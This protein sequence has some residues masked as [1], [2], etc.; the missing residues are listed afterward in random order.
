MQIF[1]CILSCFNILSTILLAS[2]CIRKLT[3]PMILSEYSLCPNSTSSTSTKSPLQAENSTFFRQTW[4]KKRSECV[5]QNTSFQV[6]NSF[7]FLRRGPP[8]PTPHLLPPPSFLGPP[9]R[10]LPTIPARFMPLCTS[11]RYLPQRLVYKCGI[12]FD[13]SIG[14][15]PWP[16]FP[17]RFVFCCSAM[18]FCWCPARYCGNMGLIIFWGTLQPNSLNTPKFGRNI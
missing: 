7:F 6:K 2:Q 10:P 4:T 9:L 11:G 3:N 8:L 13:T 16:L 15:G 12:L 17:S 1:P 5:H 14:P 18:P